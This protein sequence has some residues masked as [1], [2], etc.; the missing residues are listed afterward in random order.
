R[1]ETPG[2]STHPDLAQPRTPPALAHLATTPPSPRPLVPLPDPPQPPMTRSR[3]TTAVL[4]ADQRPLTDRRSQPRELTCAEFAVLRSSVAGIECPRP[5][6][7]ALT[8]RYA[9]KA[10]STERLLSAAP[11]S[12]LPEPPHADIRSAHPSASACP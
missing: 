3:S 5:W 12:A 4:C 8:S 9:R 1:G 11:A 2:Q 10:S 7:S 6:D